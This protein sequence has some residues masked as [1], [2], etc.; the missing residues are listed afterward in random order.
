MDIPLAQRVRLAELPV[1]HPHW[2]NF[3]IV[4]KDFK[5]HGGNWTVVI[6]IG[7]YGLQVTFVTRVAGAAER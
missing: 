1:R 4:T 2:P 5:D 3:S 7:W 6:G